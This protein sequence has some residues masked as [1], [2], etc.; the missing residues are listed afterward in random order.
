MASGN[1]IRKLT[2]PIA[3]A[4]AGGMM[5]MCALS[6]GVFWGICAGFLLILTAQMIAAWVHL[7]PGRGAGWG[8]LQALS[9][10][11]WSAAAFGFLSGI[12]VPGWV[13]VRP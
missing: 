10:M 7:R 12:A 4:F 5:L 8:E 2:I 1:S 9:L 11:I 13:A 3:L 6:I